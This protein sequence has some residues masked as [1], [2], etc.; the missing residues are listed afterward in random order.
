MPR[1]T[2]RPAKPW[3]K[4]EKSRICTK[5]IPGV[6]GPHAHR[7]VLS[8]D[9]ASLV[10]TTVPEEGLQLFLSMRR[11]GLGLWGRGSILTIR[12]LSDL[13]PATGC[14]PPAFSGPSLPILHGASDLGT[15]ES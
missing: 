6:T 5:G 12:W 7:Q 2:G 1:G 8:G 15:E 11:P 13:P 9:K 14:Q 10:G 4:Q 3:L